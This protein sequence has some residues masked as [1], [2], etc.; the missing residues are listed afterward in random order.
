MK[1]QQS[2]CCK[3]NQPGNCAYVFALAVSFTLPSAMST[4]YS[5]FSQ[6][7]CF[8]I[9]FVFFCTKELKLSSDPETFSPAFFFA[10]LSATKSFSTLACSDFG[11]AQSTTKG[12][13]GRETP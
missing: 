2:R 11:S 12:S 9:S 6:P 7:Y 13:F 10:A 4:E 5:T 8:L 1:N 3:L